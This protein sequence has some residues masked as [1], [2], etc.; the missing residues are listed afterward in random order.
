MGRVFT[1]FG[2]SSSAL[3][4]LSIA[5]AILLWFAAA[6]FTCHVCADL[7]LS[8]FPLP[9]SVFVLLCLHAGFVHPSI[10]VTSF[11]PASVAA[12]ITSA[13]S[14]L[15]LWSN[16]SIFSPVGGGVRLKQNSVYYFFMHGWG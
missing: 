11:L 1:L 16:W 6:L 15:L 7:V 4:P 13:F 12:F 9:I 5:S 2:L 14:L 10:A 3:L 8:H